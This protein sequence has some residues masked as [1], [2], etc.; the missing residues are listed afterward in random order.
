MRFPIVFACLVAVLAAPLSS[1]E[2]PRPYAGDEKREIKALSAEE[3]ESYRAG[4]GMGFAKAAE[5]NHFPGPKHVLELASEI[6]LDASQRKEAQ[7]IYEAMHAQTV[8]LGERVVVSERGLDGLF[9]AATVDE[10]SLARS[11]REIA[12]LQG[13]VRLEHLRAHLAMRSLLT[14]AQVAKYDALRGYGSGAADHDP[15]RHGH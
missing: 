5:L 12:R 15:A 9:A 13:E 7:R 1:Q 10:A 8:G 4:A 6:G 3:I 2:T 14:A 11:V